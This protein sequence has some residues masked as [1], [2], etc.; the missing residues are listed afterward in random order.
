MASARRAFTLIEL[1]VVI[2]IIALLIGLLLPAVQKV[3]E[4]ASRAKC[5]NNLKQIALACH[6]CN[7]ATGRLPPAAG[8]F[9][10]AY[11]CS[12]MFH[13]LP[14]I[15]Q[16]AMWS[17]GK[18]LDPTAQ[19]PTTTVNTAAVINIGV[20]WPCWETINGPYFM[21]MTK[22]LVYQCPTDP[23][24]GAS[25][26][27]SAT[28]PPSGGN[29]WGDG[30]ASY[31][32][33]FMI[34][35]GVANAS[36]TPVIAPASSGGN[37]DTVWDGKATLQAT[38]PDGTSNTI[39]WAEKYSRCDGAGNGGSWWYRGVFRFTPGGSYGTQDTPDSYPG[40]RYSC[41]FGGGVGMD[42]TTW[43]QSAASKFLVQPKYPLNLPTDTPPGACFNTYA[44]T[45]HENMQA[46][47]AD[48]SVHVIAASISLTTWAAIVSPS[49]GDRTGPDWTQ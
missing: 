33:N 6:N 44:S 42:G 3:R 36:T 1:L 28:T 43:T 5:Q 18:F 19:P 12:L 37:V 45:P 26:N 30:D 23:T 27:G 7:D 20:N 49:A 16:K 10:G 38:I 25:K 14:Y 11:Y 34:F 17:S 48:G 31:A 21:R 24:I 4:A 40:D 15:E 9:A 22:V 8:T 35:G 41:V 39:M 47:M 29:D 13:L 32:A 46:A 2:A